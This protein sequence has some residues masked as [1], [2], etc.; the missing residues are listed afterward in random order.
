M[1]KFQWL[2]NREPVTATRN[3]IKPKTLSPSDIARLIVNIA[4]FHEQVADLGDRWEEASP[5]PPFSKVRALQEVL[6]FFPHL[7]EQPQTLTYYDFPPAFM[8]RGWADNDK[9]FP[10]HYLEPS[11]P[12]SEYLPYP[13]LKRLSN[14]VDKGTVMNHCAYYGL[15]FYSF[16]NFLREDMPELKDVPLR[17]RGATLLERYYLSGERM[18]LQRTELTEVEQAL[19]DDDETFLLAE[20]HVGVEW[21]RLLSRSAGWRERV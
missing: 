16:L 1:E 11:R 19:E 8:G 3:L 21:D 4:A 14:A 15:C 5:I 6:P 10:P 18:C 2:H 12:W 20:D 17:M 9:T 7:F 13:I